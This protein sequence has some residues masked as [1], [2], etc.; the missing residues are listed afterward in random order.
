[1][2]ENLF[3]SILTEVCIG[4]ISTVTLVKIKNPL[5]RKQRQSPYLQTADIGETNTS[6]KEMKS[7]CK[8]S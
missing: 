7:E 5:P 2:D 6:C 8:R 1:M 3:Q 4:T